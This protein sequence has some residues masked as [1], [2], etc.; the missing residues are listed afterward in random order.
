LY[1][2][3]KYDKTDSL[4]VV[5]FSKFVAKYDEEVTLSC[6]GINHNEY[7]YYQYNDAKD[8]IVTSKSLYYKAREIFN[9]D[10]IESYKTLRSCTSIYDFINLEYGFSKEFVNTFG[11]ETCLK[12]DWK[13]KSL[14]DKYTSKFSLQEVKYLYDTNFEFEKARNNL[15]DIKKMINSMFENQKYI[16]PRINNWKLYHEIEELNHLSFKALINIKKNHD[17]LVDYYNQFNKDLRQIKSDFA[18]K[19]TNKAFKLKYE[20]STIRRFVDFLKQKNY[21]AYLLDTANLFVE[22]GSKQQHCVASYLKSV[23]NH[24]SDNYGIIHFEEY[25][26]EVMLDRFGVDENIRQCKGVRNSTNKEIQAK[27]Y[28]LIVEFSVLNTNQNIKQM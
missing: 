6:Y 9:K 5:N 21:N 17:S 12:Q 1:R 2:R 27:F 11:I 16:S 25:T 20:N 28:G 7:G 14:Y 18:N 26:V 8:I 24:S 22:E 19:E 10:R 23:L 3:C 15:K 4:Q 13:L